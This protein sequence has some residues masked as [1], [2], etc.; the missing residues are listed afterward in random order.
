[1]TQPLLL[2]TLGRMLLSGH[3]GEELLGR[4]IDL[5]ALAVLADRS[6]AVV[7][8]EEL[9]S[10]FWGEST[11]EKARH[12]LRQVV[13]RLR[14]ACGPALD[15][16]AATLRVL[17]GAIDFDARRFSEAATAGRWR[18][19]VDAWTGTFLPDCDTIGAEGFRNWLDVE[20]ERLRRLLAHSY[21]RAADELAGSDGNER[22][23]LTFRWAT[24]FP[25]DELA[26]RRHI[27]A[28]ASAGR[29]SETVATRGAFI[30]RLRAELAESPA[31]EWMSAVDTAVE[32]ART[33][34]A[35]GIAA[36]AQTQ[37]VNAPV[38]ELAVQPE[39]LAQVI[40]T[41]LTDGATT[42][43]QGWRRRPF[44]IAGVFV[45]LAAVVVSAVLIARSNVARPK[46]LPPLAVGEIASTVSSDSVRGFATLLTI[47]LA[48]IS[49]LNVVSERRVS[50]V[51]SARQ[52][53]GIEAIARAAG[54]EELLDGVLS[55][56][57]G[58]TLRADLR[59]I[60]LRSGE[61]RAAY[62]I[63]AADLTTLADLITE[64]VARDLG[65]QA[66]TARRE[67]ITTS[68]VAYRL[69]E[70]GL[71]AYHDGDGAAARR[72]CTAAL[73]EDSTFAMA[74]FYNGLAIG[75]AGS[76]EYLA[77]AAQLAQHT[78][79][80]ER[81][82]ISATW[83]RRMTDPRV[84]AWA[85]TLITRYPT[86]SQAHLIYARE[87]LDRR[88]LPA[89]LAHFRRVVEM[90]SA[91]D[92]SGTG[93]RCRACEGL[94][95]MMEVYSRLIAPDD[96]ERLARIWLRWQPRSSA[97]WYRLSGVLG[98]QRR[99]SEAHVAID[100]AAKYSVEPGFPLVHTIWWFRTNEFAE[101]DRLW[102]E[103]LRSPKPD[104]RMDALWTGVL[105][106]RTQGRMRE[107]LDAARQY[108]RESIAR[109]Q[110]LDP[111][112][113]AAMP[114]AVTLMET[115]Q[116]RQAATLFDAI[117]RVP[118]EPFPSRVGAHRA[119]YWTHTAT[120]YAAAGDT[121]RLAALED[122]VR[123][124]GMLAT[125]RHKVLYR[126]VRGLRLAAQR[127]PLEAAESFRLAQLE[128]TATYVRIHLELARA[129]LAANRPAEAIQPLVMALDGPTSASGVYATRS[130]LQV[131]LGSAYE[132]N[133]QPDSAVVQYRLAAHAWR[134]AD[135]EFAAR[136][137]QLEARIRAVARLEPVRK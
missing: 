127:R 120:A 3:G 79:D 100:S 115:G 116:P 31:D 87:M 28:L 95:G 12:S 1:M 133:R 37:R 61:T 83:G 38:S 71:R 119:M 88:N 118:Q 22:V 124:N 135:P 34:E 15:V 2:K 13:M 80:R 136:R 106:L 30:E 69:Y 113:G 131:M 96:E 47:N 103:L 16:Q 101:I 73:D 44:V 70:Q 52:T 50:E 121:T 86:E 9:Q 82:L 56:Q 84:L 40:A 93:P 18:D 20:R 5:A 43:R 10:L 7:R 125:D 39:L 29:V 137:A 63:E 21:E 123:V 35:N 102:R 81:L 122:S 62:S 105:S 134:N 49:E 23:A 41:P 11:E 51:A 108:R 67:G 130:E 98:S 128:P 46:R 77:R 17:G 32:R 4:R 24:Q 66:S 75:G 109:G 33:V 19:A 104:V 42:V 36:R 110:G 92:R 64:Q 117:A 27:D 90:D 97:A 25:L 65:V 91:I 107:A 58:N 99:Y 129:L 76:D 74:A 126:Y 94:V 72:F 14:H 55:L 89:S 6:P 26:H 45:A 85:E 59:R 68:I 111:D 48:R 60:D 57:P 53:A 8:R 54:A 78:S 114:E 112:L 132:R